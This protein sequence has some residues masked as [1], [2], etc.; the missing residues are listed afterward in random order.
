MAVIFCF[1]GTGN[2][3]YAANNIAAGIGANVLPMRDSVKCGDDVIGFVFPVYFFGLPITVERFLNDMCITDKSAYVFVVITM[4]GLAYG[5]DGAVNEKLERQDIKLSYSFKLRMVS[6]YLPEFR[7]NDSDA[8]WKSCDKK[9]RRII[10]DVNR[11]A[12][13]KIGSYSFV[14]KFVHRS[15]PPLKGNCTASFSVRKCIECGLCEK[16]CPN[17]NIILEQGSPRFGNNCNLCLRCLNSCPVDAIDYG[18]FTR[19]KKR[20]KNRRI[21]IEEIIKLNCKE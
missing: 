7:V 11:R 15:Y 17:K 4:G 3:L 21:S 12:V 5:V 14:N 2:S 10:S 13:V 18:K 6:N 20:Y 19:G 16:I 8:L 1:S 9:L